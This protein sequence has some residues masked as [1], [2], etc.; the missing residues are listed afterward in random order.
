MP[1]PGGD[2]RDV[3]SRVVDTSDAGA[4]ARA[5]WRQ[6]IDDLS[7]LVLRGG[8]RVCGIPDYESYVAHARRHHPDAP[9]M[10]FEQFFRQR[11]DARYGGRGGGPRCC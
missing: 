11:L 3:D 8:R 9:V 6:R 4:T 2:G 7:R 5:D 1:E 10:S